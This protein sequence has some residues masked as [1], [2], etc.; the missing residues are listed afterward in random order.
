M[1][2]RRGAPVRRVPF[3]PITTSSANGVKLQES[4]CEEEQC[5]ECRS[6]GA[7]LAW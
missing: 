4:T 3:A 7:A 5:G 6:N 2:F 1:S